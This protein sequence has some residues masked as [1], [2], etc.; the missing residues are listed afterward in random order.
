[1]KPMVIT[2]A[3]LEH[4]ALDAQLL[5]ATLQNAA[6]LKELVHARELELIERLEAGA[7]IDS[8]RLTAVV[9]RSE[10]RRITPWKQVA[11]DLWAQLKLD[12]DVMES[13]T[14]ELT[15]PSVYPHLVVMGKGGAGS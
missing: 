6:R 9:D 4:F 1:M 8:K 11:R 10:T 5:K 2:E 3:E 7:K 15:E 14:K 13:K 12:P